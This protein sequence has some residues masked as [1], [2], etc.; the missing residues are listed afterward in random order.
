MVRY[1]I[2]AAVVFSW[3]AVQFFGLRAI[4]YNPVQHPRG[5]IIGSVALLL[6]GA[7]WFRL[8]WSKWAVSLLAAL[9]ICLYAY[10]ITTK[11]LPPCTTHEVACVAH[12][13]AQPFLT[14]VALGVLFAP[15]PL[16]TRSGGQ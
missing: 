12:L 8:Q 7:L 6:A 9:F 5:W 15:W 10:I 4:G 11:G 3:A 16:T 13:V 14:M 2:A 1:R